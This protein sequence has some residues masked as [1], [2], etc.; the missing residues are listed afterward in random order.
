M[1]KILVIILLQLAFA[2][3]S[4]F[5]KSLRTNSTD[6]N[7]NEV[8]ALKTELLVASSEKKALAQLQKLISM[9]RGSGMEPTLRFRLGELYMRM[10]K[11]DRF[12]EI[13]RDSETIVKLVP[14]LAKKASEKANII[15]AIA[16]YDYIERKFSSYRDLDLVLFNSAFARQQIRQD[17]Q[18]KNLYLKMIKNFPESVLIPEGYLALGEMEFEK[19][20]F[21]EAATFFE[22]IKMYQKSKIYPYGRYKLAW[23]YFNLKRNNEAL[24]ELESVVDYGKTNE[25]SRS[26]KKLDLRKEALSDMVLFYADFMPAKGAISYFT[27]YAGA[28]EAGHYLVKLAKLYNRHGKKSEQ[29][30]VLNDLIRSLPNSIFLPLAYIDLTEV[31]E[32]ERRRPEVVKVLEDFHKLCS[33]DSS[34]KKAFATADFSNEDISKDK[35]DCDQNFDGTVVTL[36]QKWDKLSRKQESDKNLQQATIRGYELYLL[37]A[38]GKKNE[39]LMHYAFSEFLFSKKIYSRASDE[40][41]ATAKKAKDKQMIHDASYASIVSLQNSVSDKWSKENESRYVEL[42][43]FYIQKNPKGKHIE[44]VEFKRAFIIYDNG[45]FDEAAPILKDLG[46]RYAGKPQGLKAQDLYLDILNSKK[47]YKAIKTYTAA[48]LATKLSPARDKAITSIYRQAYFSDIQKMEGQKE[49]EAAYKEYQK[50]SIENKS[51]DLA[52]KAWWNSLGIL[53]KLDLKR[54]L[55]DSAYKFTQMFP[56]DSQ[57]KAALLLAVQNYENIADLN[58][59][60]KVLED[61]I[62][63]DT[64]KQDHWMELKA[65]YQYLSGQYNESHAIYDKLI[66]KADKKRR[67]DLL[68]KLADIEKAK[69]NTSAYDMYEKLIVENGVQPAAS[70]AQAYLTTKVWNKGDYSTAF[71]MAS[72][73]IAMPK[74]ASPQAKAKARYIQANILSK[75]FTNQSVKSTQAERIAL[76]LSLKTEKLDKAQRAYQDVLRYSDAET[77]AKSLHEMAMLYGHYAK[78]IRSIKLPDGVPEKDAKAFYAEME[79]LA[80]PMEEKE[81]E[82][83]QD[84]FKTITKLNV[85]DGTLGKVRERLNEINNKRNPATVLEVVVPRVLLPRPSGV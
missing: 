34:W 14:T 82:S 17:A 12:F 48:L 78:S 22:K 85:Y 23:A 64:E 47:D 13:N 80:I 76:V 20:K 27:K 81:V 57:R 53:Q 38:G 44:A 43:S 39:V 33:K 32:S 75:E 46:E 4:E 11:T 42:A 62:K 28:E 35:L 10:S 67:T 66:R 19:H 29:I 56:S 51:S 3:S 79:N 74:D 49:L 37:R 73:V 40:Y 52:S 7:E 70:E 2:E 16:E 61:L 45:R 71:K 77:T 18:A 69:N 72:S 65:D 5:A 24:A 6:E 36:T 30:V 21:K 55:A 9:Y 50:F 26:N 1:M 54:E 84:A 58:K 25:Y 31:Y 60:A 83:L 68:I 41:F 59:S 8:R 63:I 15:K